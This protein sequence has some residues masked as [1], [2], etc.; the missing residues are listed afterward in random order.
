MV[1]ERDYPGMS[2]LERMKAIESHA[3]GRIAHI[4]NT[5]MRTML[6]AETTILGLWDA[7]KRPPEWTEFHDAVGKWQGA[8]QH[9]AWELKKF[10][11]ELKKS[12]AGQDTARGNHE[13]DS[14]GRRRSTI[15][16][17]GADRQ[18]STQSRLRS[19]PQSDTGGKD[20]REQCPQLPR[21]PARGSAARRHAGTRRTELHFTDLEQDDAQAAQMKAINSASELQNAPVL[22]KRENF[23]QLL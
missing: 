18:S 21:C 9:S 2:P 3:T 22:D 14:S 11:D 7:Y 6:K 10:A 5:F 1:A 20:S 13:L 4:H 19:F 12:D 8:I 17:T 15:T 16:R 23:P